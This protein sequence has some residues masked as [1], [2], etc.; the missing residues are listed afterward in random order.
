MKTK[1]AYTVR[2]TRAPGETADSI[3]PVIVERLNPVELETVVENCIDRGLIAGLKTTAAHG[4]AE[5]VAAQIAREFTL[6]RGVQFGQYFYGRPYLSGTVDANGRLTS[7]N[8]INVRLYKGE[9]FRL[10]LDDFSFTFDGAGDAVK[11]DSVYGD[12][13]DAGGN[14][15][16]QVVQGAPVKINGR[17]L[18]AAGD[19]DKVTF[20]EAGGGATVEVTDF[21]T[22]SA[23][24]LSFAWPA[25]LV[26]GKTYTVR[27]ERTDVN[28][29][30]RTGTGRKVA[31]VAGAVPPGP[32]PEPIAESDD[33]TV[34][35]MTLTDGGQS[36]TFTAGHTWA[37]TGEGLFGDFGE[38]HSWIIDTASVEG[39]GGQGGI[40]LG[41]V[42]SADG[43][44][45]TLSSDAAAVPAGTYANAKVKLTLVDDGTGVE[46]LEIPITFV[47][48]E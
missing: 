25:G 12:T 42:M 37:M 47:V 1:L 32:E 36:E 7:E 31:V 24:M 19:T 22:Q 40:P 14:T 38:G 17:N 10:T 6:G 29:V 39:L 3:V 18:Y 5:G 45:A 21:A 4:I 2:N 41:C 20:A 27:V 44:S 34:K 35:V 11:I 46:A 15:Y 48:E 30:T 33:G 13:T 16:G 23:D 8:R 9:A 28:G 43:T 26:P